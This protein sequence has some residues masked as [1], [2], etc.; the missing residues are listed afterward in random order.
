[1]PS[2][3][4]ARETARAAAIDGPAADGDGRAV[5]GEIRIKL[6]DL[7][8]VSWPAVA[9]DESDLRQR[10]PE[11]RVREEA[12]PIPRAIAQVPLGRRTIFRALDLMLG[13][14]ATIVFLPVAAFVAWRIRAHDGGPVLFRQERVG[15]DGRTFTCY[16]FRTMRPDAEEVLAEL[17]EEDA[18]RAEFESAYKLRSDPRITAI[19]DRLRQTGLDELPQL[20]NV[21]NGTMSLVGPRPLQTEEVARY[22]ELGSVL[23]AIKPGVTGPWQISGRNDIPY[24][25]RVRLDAGLAIGLSAWTYL[26][27][28]VETAVR[29]L[30]GRLD[31]GY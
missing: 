2:G 18:F 19:G 20:L 29:F 12:P 23:V 8:K 13:L 24:A 17:L 7:T 30:T 14:L 27:Y 25:E 11:P 28:V 6:W 10:R 15:R 21:L 31:G 16:K 26:R 3:E 22:G 4:E 9:S 1:M 5:D